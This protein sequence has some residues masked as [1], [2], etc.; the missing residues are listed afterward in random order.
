MQLCNQTITSA[1]SSVV[2][3]TLK[4]HAAPSG[5]LFPTSLLCQFNFQYGSGGANTLAFVQSS[6]D[7]GNSWYDLAATSFGTSNGRTLMTIS[8]SGMATV[9]PTF[10][11]L[12]ANTSVNALGTLLRA[13]VITTGTYSNT[14][15]RIDVVG[16][17][18]AYTLG[19]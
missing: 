7:G 14:S 6:A 2:G 3:N 17:V 1:A 13:L 12:A 19:D 11:T 10:G 15:L 16:P 4:L 8:S 5:P 18:D 9:T